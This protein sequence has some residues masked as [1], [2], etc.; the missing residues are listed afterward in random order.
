MLEIKLRI[1][2]Q[3]HWSDRVVGAG[4]AEQMNKITKV[5]KIVGLISVEVHF[6]MAATKMTFFPF[7]LVKLYLPGW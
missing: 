1:K 6:V 4:V 2:I 3:N 5:S 7:L